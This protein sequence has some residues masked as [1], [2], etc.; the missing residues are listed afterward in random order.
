MRVVLAPAQS[1]S[2]VFTTNATPIVLKNQVPGQVNITTIP[3]LSDVSM[4]NPSN[5]TVLIYNSS[6]QKFHLNTLP[7]DGGS[8]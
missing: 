4:D 1:I 6:D 2:A 7:V 5:N 3:G 8:F